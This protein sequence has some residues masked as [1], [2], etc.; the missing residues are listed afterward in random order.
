MAQDGAGELREEALDQVEP[1]AVLGREGKVEAAWRPGVEPGSGFP[2][3][4]CGMGF[5]SKLARSGTAAASSSN[6]SSF[7]RVQA[8][9]SRGNQAAQGA[10]LSGTP[11]RRV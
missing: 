8:S 5:F 3:N 9:R 6:S 1:G 7:H 2:R 10:L 4:V 11:R